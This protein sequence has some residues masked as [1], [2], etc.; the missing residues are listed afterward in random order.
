VVTMGTIRIKSAAAYLIVAALLAASP[1]MAQR[2]SIDEADAPAPA[3]AA[4]APAAGAELQEVT[5]S[6]SAI[7]ISGY[8]QPTPVTSLGIQQLQSSAMPDLSDA[9][10]TLPAFA[11]SS[12]PQNSNESNN[13][14]NGAAGLDQLNLRNLGP[15]RTLLLIDGQRI[16]NGTIYGGAETS[17]I[18]ATLVQRVD[19]VTGG[20]SAIWGSDAVAGVVNYVLN[21]NYNGLGIE[22]QA[23]NNV[24]SEHPMYS[25]TITF[26]TGFADNRGHIE[27]SLGIWR[28]P[29]V[30]YSH[31]QQGFAF[32]RLVNN[33]NCPGGPDGANPFVPQPC[34]PGQ[35]SLIHANNVG[36][37]SAT[38]GGL[39]YT[40][41]NALGTIA[42]CPLAGTQFVGPNATEAYFNPGNVSNNFYANGG[43]GNAGAQG[44]GEVQGVPQTTQTA[45]LLGSF[46]FTDHVELTGQFN[47][48][49]TS[50]YEN[51][52]TDIQYGNSNPAVIYSGNPFI[53]AQTLAQMGAFGLN[54]LSIGTVNTNPFTGSY[55]SLQAQVGSVG[56]LV[57]F[58]SRRLM[59]GVV[60]LDGDFGGG[61]WTW[62]AYYER[63][64]THQFETGLNNP[65]NTALYAAENAVRVGDYGA[66][67]AD[68]SGNVYGFLPMTYTAAAFP[69]PLGL[70]PGT[71]T[72]ASNL[73]PKNSP[74]FTP[75]CSPLNIFGSGPGVAS[76]AAMQYVNAIARA[77]GN[78]DHANLVQ[79]VG[80]VNIQGKLPIGT[81]AGP[82]A[83][84]AGLVYRN[85]FAIQVNCG[86]NCSTVNFP[87]GNYANF[88]GSYNV[89][90]GSVELNAPLLKDHFVKDLSVDAAWRGIDYSTSGFVQTYKFGLVSQMTDILRLRASYSRDIRAGDM[91]ELFGQPQPIGESNIDP[92]TG[93]AVPS[94]VVAEGNRNVQP[95]DAETRTAG[96]V[97]TPMQGLIGSIDWY[98][99]RIKNVINE[100]LPTSEIAALCIQGNQAFCQDF[101]Y[102]NSL[103]GCRG[104]ACPGVLYG[105]IS[106]A[107]NSDW[108]SESGIDF[109]ADYRIPFG[110]GAL[111]VNTNVNYV[112]ALRYSSVGSVCDPMNGVSYDQGSYP[113]C[114]PQG[115][116]KFKG[117]VAVSYSQ[118]G[119]LGTVQA[120][121]IGAAHLVSNWTSGVQVDN[122]D[123]PFQTYVDLRAS[124]SF[125]FGL[126]LYGAIDNTFNRWAPETGASAFSW[127]TLYEAPW[128]DYIYDGYGRVWRLGFRYKL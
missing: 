101:I 71:I 41:N 30:Y 38:V 79:N 6:A 107:V 111:D 108:Q 89:K 94:F 4:T 110:P 40:C 29:D 23:S 97:F 124:Y 32:Q 98:Y 48:G 102:G 26:G 55:P 90:E 119:W 68:P 56:M 43:T 8:Q 114:I 70:A 14:S 18:P 5:V 7:S 15:N 3:P 117:N 60:G 45:F 27:G 86:V 113:A 52:Y 58:E 1:A 61:N 19:V 125:P 72:C 122:N 67:I 74:F 36:I 9:V 2:N 109:L 118:G 87:Y 12:S 115:V 105:V 77:G 104:L 100:G 34:A 20:A 64:E 54:Q 121:M 37:S 73:L 81:S 42:N 57:L 128:Q 50:F 65:T 127:N 11:A 116:P 49:Y 96:L 31:Q 66:T 83:M 62:N 51:S 69:N 24:Q 75:N 28:V 91:F 63:S 22:G 99:I 85:E 16:V 53:P 78:A 92:R 33:P 17:N 39:I 46:K 80:A 76:Q 59:R 103:N 25:G 35:P 10:R 13:I 21:H 120:R 112:F 106:Q 47:Y 126:Q 123:I 44:Y 82:V 84:A 95:E 88:V 93:N